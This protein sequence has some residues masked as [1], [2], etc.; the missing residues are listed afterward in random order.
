MLFLLHEKKASERMIVTRV[1]YLVIDYGLRGIVGVGGSLGITIGLVQVFL[2]LGVSSSGSNI[3][4]I[5][6]EF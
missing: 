3:L 4:D 5:T 1:K 2:G 6:F